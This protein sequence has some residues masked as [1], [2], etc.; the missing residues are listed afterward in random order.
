M[1][2][3]DEAKNE[4]VLQRW[5]KIAVIIAIRIQGVIPEDI[6]TVRIL[7]YIYNERYS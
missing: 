4:K 6:F 7:L 3:A 5:Q 1:M 2:T